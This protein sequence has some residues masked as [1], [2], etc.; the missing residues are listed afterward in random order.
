[1]AME[2][3]FTSAPKGLKPGSTGF[4]T[5]A[6]T[7][8]MPAPMI[9]KLESLGGYRPVFEVGSPDEWKN[10]P[11]YAHL[12]VSIGG[13][14]YSVLSHICF[15]GADHQGR[16]NKYAHHLVLDSPEFSPA[17]PAWVMMQPGV[18]EK[19]WIG[20][21]RILPANSKL[22]PVGT[23][24]LGVCEQWKRLTG[25][26]GWAGQLAQAFVL[27]ATKPVYVIYK[28]GT[29]L[30]PLIN[31]AISLLP[32]PMR[33]RV[34][35]STYFDQLQA[36]MLCSWRCCV[37]GTA[38]A[39][40]A[41]G[42]ATSGVLIDMTRPLG[43]APPNR[44]ADMARTGKDSSD[45][46]Q[47][48]SQFVVVSPPVGG[49][50]PGKDSAPCFAD[51]LDEVTTLKPVQA[52]TP[53]PVLRVSQQQAVAASY[54]PPRRPNLLLWAGA[55]L[56]PLLVL[57]VAFVIVWPNLVK[58][59]DT[60]VKG[61]APGLADRVKD[62]ET[63]LGQ[64]ND[65]IKRL[66]DEREKT[67][68]DAAAKAERI[69]DLDGQVATLTRDKDDFKSRFEGAEAQI[70]QLQRRLDPRNNP[71]TDNNKTKDQQ[72]PK[73][74][75]KVTTKPSAAPDDGGIGFVADME[76]H[77]LVA[78]GTWGDE[79]RDDSL[80]LDAPKGTAKLRFDGPLGDAIEIANPTGSG[81]G[82]AG[83]V[84]IFQRLQNG[85]RG[86]EI[87]TIRLEGDK[88]VCEW[89][90]V[91]AMRGSG[92]TD[93]KGKSLQLCKAVDGSMPYSVL[94]LMD[95]SGKVLKKYQFC[96]RD[97]VARPTAI[98]GKQ[99]GEIPGVEAD[100][101]FANTQPDGEWQAQPDK[102]FSRKMSFKH[103]KTQLVM[104][105]ELIPDHKAGKV[106]IKALWRSGS[107]PGEIQAQLGT[108]DKRE[109]ALPDEIK[110]DQT[111][112]GK[113]EQYLKDN[114]PVKLRAR[115]AELQKEIAEFRASIEETRA[116]I[117]RN[118]EV[119][120]KVKELET[121]RETEK[122]LWAQLPKQDGKPEKPDQEA[123]N[124]DKGKDKGKG[125]WQKWREWLDTRQK[126]DAIDKMIK[127][128]EEGQ[129][130]ADREQLDKRS[131]EA[132]DIATNL[133]DWIPNTVAELEKKRREKEARLQEQKAI[134]A[135]RDAL[136]DKQEIIKAAKLTLWVVSKSSG[137]R[138]ADVSVRSQ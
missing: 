7:A 80:A 114:D 30:L 33:W 79:A 135:R 18:M 31:E 98:A 13:H 82:E 51:M 26:A 121:L 50:A 81:A 117:R 57:A 12:R 45:G 128:F 46:A 39:R 21:P 58:P 92:A 14:F 127:E 25:D 76:K 124:R 16:F 32:E 37:A 42:N 49:W 90:I 103:A 22:V 43:G 63:K 87:A 111:A 11:V 35:F 132:G 77:R 131:R 133:K 60:P 5:V 70:K 119:S 110:K 112:I 64:A 89:F 94:E 2:L 3:H 130:K 134:P 41:P 118:P 104:D 20:E 108:L 4:C 6:L 105:V 137:A 65:Y 100:P 86:P 66:E 126:A 15:A 115:Q 54:V 28:P 101:V 24:P 99:P 113:Y 96:S 74:P 34:T 52:G 91:K 72:V 23:N 85:E 27:D 67:K 59:P 102:D 125:L 116:K 47:A 61:D 138:L 75:P 44:F 17:G 120:V 97:A 122:D 136:R 56:W 88:V 123:I 53:A 129:T 48:D 62:L 69:A 107:T 73:P 10:P 36:G 109:R 95:Q 19:R 55:I 1:M 83:K 8:G 78:T 71:G 9:Q 40:A 38:A 29:D 68:A 106:Q 84:Q 93:V